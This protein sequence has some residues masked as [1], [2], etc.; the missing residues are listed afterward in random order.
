MDLIWGIYGIEIPEKE[1]K[2]H[3]KR[4]WR[5]DWAWPLQKVA[6]EREGGLWNAGRH[7]RGAGYIAD[8]Q[9]YNEAQRLGWRV[10]RFTPQQ[11][12]T[13]EAQTCMKKILGGSHE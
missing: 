5:F 11:L 1:Y 9:K 8:M 12:K 7:V 2:F 3:P 6:A 10:F 4:R 13:G